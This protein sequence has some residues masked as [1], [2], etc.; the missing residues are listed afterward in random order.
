VSGVNSGDQ[1]LSTLP[2]DTDLMM[3]SYS[4]DTTAA[5]YNNSLSGQLSFYSVDS[6]ID[7]IETETMSVLLQ[8]R[9]P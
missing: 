5:S 7:D 4:V 9:N 8:T 2:I 6:D 3:G 1:T